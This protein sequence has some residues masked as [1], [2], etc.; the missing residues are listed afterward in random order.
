MSHPAGKFFIGLCLWQAVAYGVLFNSFSLFIKPIA[1]G[2]DW[3][4]TAVSILSTLMSLFAAFF[5]SFTGRLMNKVNSRIWFT[6]VAIAIS[7]I[8]FGFANASALWHFYT[9]AAL[10]GIMS[11]LGI[12]ITAQVTVP[13]WFAKPA[14]YMGIAAACGGVG[15]IIA[16]PIISRFLVSGGYQAGFMF[17]AVVALCVLVPMGFFVIRFRPDEVGARPY[18]IEEVEAQQPAANAAG[19][20][21]VSGYTEAEARRMPQYWLIWLYVALVPM[22]SAI[23]IHV[24]GALG[25]KG[26]SLILVG[27]VV[28]SYQFGVAAGQ[29]VIG[30]CNDKLGTMSTSVLFTAAGA[31]ACLAMAY[32]NQPTIWVLSLIVFVLGCVRALVTVHLA[33]V[34]RKSFGMKAYG[35][36]FSLYFSIGSIITAG[37]F[38]AMGAIKDFTGSY[39]GIFMIIVGVAIICML[40]LIAIENLNKKQAAK[41]NSIAA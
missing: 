19:A 16:A 6:S 4:I 33:V 31:L 32:Y 26:L 35:P 37:Y 5:L 24:P 22:F 38:M 40:A 7:L 10:F 14:T 30:W 29:F 11:A 23:F 3:S 12:F 18:G 17:Q 25:D 8:M 1:T 41:T 39:A 20:A 28:A 27:S 21:Q 2:N 36:I 34:V 9:L 13:N 15:A